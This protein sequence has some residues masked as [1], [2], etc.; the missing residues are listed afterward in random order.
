M[1]GSDSPG[2]AARRRGAGRLRDRLLARRPA[3]V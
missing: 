1:N 3:A 2:G